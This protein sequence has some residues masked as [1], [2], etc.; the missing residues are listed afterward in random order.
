MFRPRFANARAVAAPKPLETPNITAQ[1]LRLDLLSD[2]V[3]FLHLILIKLVL[4][5]GQA[6]TQDSEASPGE[7]TKSSRS[8]QMD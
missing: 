1:S 5:P 7:F 3:S 8:V 2:M 6:L 4:T